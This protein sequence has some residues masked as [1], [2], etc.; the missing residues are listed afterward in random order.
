MSLRAVTELPIS[1]P[2]SLPAYVCSFLVIFD[3]ECFEK[4]QQ[5]PHINVSLVE[6]T[7]GPPGFKEWLSPFLLMSP[8]F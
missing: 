8:V 2:A 7:G 1:L 5:R 6:L 4:A 3:E